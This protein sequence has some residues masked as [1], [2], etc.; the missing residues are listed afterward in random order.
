MKISPGQNF[1]WEAVRLK[2][3]REARL[4]QLLELP[5]QIVRIKLERSP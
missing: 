4:L 2:L 1:V 3:G 5:D